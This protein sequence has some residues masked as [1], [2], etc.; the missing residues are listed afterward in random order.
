MDSIEGRH[1]RQA[2]D[3]RTVGRIVRVPGDVLVHL[4][5]A[6]D[7]LGPSL[8][9][10]GDLDRVAAVAGLSKFHFHRLVAAVSGECW[11]SQRLRRERERIRRGGRGWSRTLPD[12]RSRSSRA[13]SFVSE[14]GRLPASNEHLTIAQLESYGALEDVEPVAIGMDARLVGAPALGRA[15]LRRD[16]PG[17]VDA[18]SEQ[19]GRGAVGTLTSRADD[20]VVLLVDEQTRRLSCRAMRA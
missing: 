11:T 7:Q 15:H 10:T 12:R 9:R 18:R 6:R 8:C 16:L 1:R 19:P 17:L 5:S 20:D 13:A 4:R 2:P 14:A 3:K